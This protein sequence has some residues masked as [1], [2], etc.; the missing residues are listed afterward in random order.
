MGRVH[1][2]INEEVAALLWSQPDGV[3]ALAKLDN[4]GRLYRSMGEAEGLCLEVVRRLLSM[5]LALVQAGDTNSMESASVNR[6]NEVID[7]FVCL[8]ERSRGGSLLR[9]LARLSGVVT[10][11]KQIHGELDTLHQDYEVEYAVTD[12]QGWKAA[13]ETRCAGVV[14]LFE[15]ALSSRHRLH[16]E[17]ASADSDESIADLSHKLR[18]ASSRVTDKGIPTAESSSEMR[19]VLQLYES[20][21]HTL[22]VNIQVP[23]VPLWYVADDEVELS[24]HTPRCE[25]PV[26]SGYRAS[27]NGM[28]VFVKKLKARVR[29]DRVAT[30]ALLRRLEEW[31]ELGSHHHVLQF[32]GANHFAQHPFVV[33]E[34]CQYGNFADYFAAHGQ[35]E[36]WR[37]FFEAALGLEHLHQQKIF[38][39][40]LR[41]H[42]LLVGNGRQAKIGDCESMGSD[43]DQHL[44]SVESTMSRRSTVDLFSV[45]RAGGI[46]GDNR[47]R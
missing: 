35:S 32:Y 13:W 46:Y 44:L 30:E 9:R 41:C 38:H 15:K 43:Y 10:T 18:R 25:G 19:L 36:I 8:M 24:L 42:N 45:E 34:Y 47:C 37:L 40:H 2:V 33:S 21:M 6:H 7:R 23:D 4:A 39:G 22:H 31:E 3:D 16:V 12:A 20:V 27:W 11:I 1:G 5:R 26:W 28:D 17:L 29:Y 14:G